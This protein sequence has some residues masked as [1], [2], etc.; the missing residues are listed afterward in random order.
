MQQSLGLAYRSGLGLDAGFR[1]R[2]AIRGEVIRT[3]LFR[4]RAIS[5][6]VE[7]EPIVTLAI[8]HP[9]A[10][11]EA[12]PPVGKPGFE[13]EKGIF[14]VAA[15][16]A[17]QVERVIA[18]LTGPRAYGIEQK[19]ERRK[20][21]DRFVGPAQQVLHDS[22][23]LGDEYGGHCPSLQPRHVNRNSRRQ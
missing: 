2:R 8:E 7:I 16:P 17:A 21:V 12:V 20:M 3:D 19:L 6:V 23:E 13:K 1:D 15:P 10:G 4:V 5:A 11:V 22:V 14:I 18:A 9:A